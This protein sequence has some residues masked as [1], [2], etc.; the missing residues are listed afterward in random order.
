[1]PITIE[2]AYQVLGVSTSSTEAEVK[3]AYKKLALKTHPDKN[4][5]DPEASKKFLRVSEAYKRITDP[6]SFRDE[7][8]QD[9]PNEEEMAAMFN[10]MFAEMMGFGMGGGGGGSGF[11]DMPSMF[12]LMEVMMAQEMGYGLDEDEDDEDSY[13]YDEEDLLEMIGRSGMPPGGFDGGYFD[14]D[15]EED[16]EDDYDHS[17]HAANGMNFGDFLLRE[18]LAGANGG[19]KGIGSKGRIPSRSG[20]NGKAS[21]ATKAVGD[22][23]WET[24]SEEEQS[25]GKK[26][27]KSNGKA[28]KKKS[29]GKQ[30]GKSYMFENEYDD[31]EDDDEML[32]AMMAQFAGQL[33]G[34]GDGGDLD[35]NWANINEV[36]MGH[37]GMLAYDDDDSDE[38]EGNRHDAEKAKKKK[39][40]KNSNKNH[41]R[42]KKEREKSSHLTGANEKLDSGKSQ[43][44]TG[45]S[46]AKTDENSANGSSKNYLVD[47]IQVNDR[48]LVHGR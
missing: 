22:D 12:D 29:N 5:N 26:G 37:G 10:M 6:D 47:D 40:S 25:T 13:G 46:T 35:R 7:D 33:G 17:Q 30:S 42:N 48:V 11:N 2:E 39:K 27:S 34:G 19:Q 31:A 16:G 36:L 18:M 23:D 9:V 3:S 8:E 14:S 38:G 4:P 32:A 43:K 21:S 20:K 24:E 1:M 15:D 45:K 44:S 41:K 28:T